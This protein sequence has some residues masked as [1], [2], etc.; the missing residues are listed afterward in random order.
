MNSRVFAKTIIIIILLLLCTSCADHQPTGDRAAAVRAYAEENA[1][2][3]RLCSEE[4]QDLYKEYPVGSYRIDRI[5]DDL[6]QKTHDNY[7]A[8]AK[9]TFRSRQLA[10]LFDSGLFVSIGV[11]ADSVC[12]Y[13]SLRGIVPS[14][15]YESLTYIP[16]GKTSDL[17][18][19]D[20]RMQFVPQ[21]GGMLGTIPGSDNSLF[22]YKISRYYYYCIAKF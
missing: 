2:L 19:Y 20:E 8:A 5:R 13:C 1:E 11:D 7:G 18:G 3:L 9:S 16:S 22:Y 4:L 14:S 21:D 15:V 6:M 17:F 12:Y 10:E